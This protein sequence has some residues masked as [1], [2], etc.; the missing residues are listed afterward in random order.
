MITSNKKIYIK[1]R[2]TNNAYSK[3]NK[4]R[5]KEAQINRTIGS[6]RSAVNKM[7]ANSEEQASI[8]KDII[9]VSPTSSSWNEELANYWNSLSVDISETGKELEVGFTY[10]ISSIDKQTYITKINSGIS[11][12][13]DKL[14]SDADL[15]KYIETRINNIIDSFKSR[16]ETASN[17]KDPVLRDKQMDEAYKLKY[18]QLV[19]IESERFKVGKPIEPFDYMLYRWCLIYRDVANEKSLMS[20]SP[21]IR[22]YLHSKDD[23]KKEVKAKQTNE[24]NRIKLLVKVTESIDSMENLIYAMGESGNVKDMNDDTAVYEFVEKLSKLREEDFIVTANDPD[25]NIIGEIEK[26]ISVGILTR[27]LGSKV[28][29]NP[30]SDETPIGGNVQEAVMYFKNKANAG[31]ISDFKTKYKNLKV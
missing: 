31:V 22:F 16:L 11:V 9:N 14:I 3:A 7:I 23:I 8:M 18:D 12:E 2:P 10:D 27:T 17:I 13:K 4:D 19:D 28:I 1:V 20:K 29:Y 15:E 5:I 21:K 25:L 26:Y 6:S 24:R 30:L